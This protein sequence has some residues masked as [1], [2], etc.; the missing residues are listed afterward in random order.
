MFADNLILINPE[1]SRAFLTGY[2][3][4]QLILNLMVVFPFRRCENATVNAFE[5][6]SFSYSPP[7]PRVGPVHA[8]EVA[9]GVAAEV[10]GVL[11]VGPLLAAGQE[12]QHSLLPQEKLSPRELWKRAWKRKRHYLRLTA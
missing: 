3:T 12:N 6:T 11:E 8:A 4:C 1:L 7:S 9:A 5:M 10:G 2:L